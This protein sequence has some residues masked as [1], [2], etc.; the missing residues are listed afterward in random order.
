M[1][2]I[3]TTG[4]LGYIGS[5]TVVSLLK[6][7][8][9]VLIIDSLI[10]S[11]E[12][13][14]CKIKKIVEKEKLKGKLFLRKGDLRNKLWLES[15]F[16]EFNDI[17][18]AIE[19]VIHFAGLK[20]VNESILNPL[21][22]WD[23]NVN[24]TLSLLNVMYKFSCYKLIFSSSA[25]VYKTDK[26]K[27][28]SENNVLGPINPYG[29]TKLCIERILEDL[30]KS[31]DNKWRIACLRY[32]NP[33]GAHDSGLI[34]ENPLS[35]H[36]NIFPVLFKVINKDIEKLP[37]Y[38]S[39]WPTKDGTCVRDY[40][41]VMDLADAHVAAL[42][43]ISDNKPNLIYLNI[44]TGNGVSVLELVQTFSEVNSCKIPYYLTDRRQ[45]DSPFV[46]A[47]NSLALKL[48]PWEPKKNLKDMCVDSWS[49]FL[50]NRQINNNSK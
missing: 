49:W 2:T 17:N 36:L 38:G 15:I 9:N 20:S 28:L 45:G 26:N 10:N 21:L 1:H 23:M 16:Q 48:I 24:S 34:G 5:H 29:K 25:T 39:D 13:T 40:I 43:N 7:G 50:K 35:D 6:K 27:K 41:H 12:E 46:V 8:F 19:S 44:G 33:C 42:L 37:I 30:I 14:F 22:Y 3:L 47:D 32:F 18:M 31:G 11:K 4:G